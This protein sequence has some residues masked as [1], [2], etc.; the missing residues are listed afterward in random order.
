MIS[1]CPGVPEQ[2]KRKHHKKTTQRQKN[3]AGLV[4]FIC[5]RFM[6]IENYII[7][8]RVSILDK[9]AQANNSFSINRK[10]SVKLKFR[11]FSV[12]G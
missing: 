10:L 7:G 4:L 11:G 9:D 1:C 6:D 8:I 3:R 2:E 5:G 12:N